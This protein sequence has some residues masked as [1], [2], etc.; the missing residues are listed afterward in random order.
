L[1]GY[2]EKIDQISIKYLTD[3]YQKY[4]L[5]V[6]SVE[7]VLRASFFL[8]FRNSVA[9]FRHSVISNRV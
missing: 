8:N 2:Q 1:N 5:V 4:L 7:N 3:F 9:S 6:V